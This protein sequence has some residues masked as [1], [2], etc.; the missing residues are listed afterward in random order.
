MNDE[1]VY[2]NWFKVSA[3]ENLNEWKNFSCINPQTNEKLP[4]KLG[5][6]FKT[7]DEYIKSGGKNPNPTTKKFIKNS[8]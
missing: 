2:I 8:F 4:H 1:F 3:N 5:Y 7:F 6:Y